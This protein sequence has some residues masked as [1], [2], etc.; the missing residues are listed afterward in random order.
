[1]KRTFRSIGDQEGSQEQATKSEDVSTTF[2]WHKLEKHRD[3]HEAEIEVAK[4]LIS[5]FGIYVSQAG[6]RG[7]S[8]DIEI[9]DGFPTRSSRRNSLN[10]IRAGKYEVKSLW[11]K[12]ENS[13]FD[14][15]FKIG[16]RGERL[17]GRRDAA[18][19]AFVLKLEQYLEEGTCETLVQL[20]STF[21]GPSM[22]Q[23]FEQIYSFIDDALARKHSLRFTESLKNLVGKVKS[24]P[25]LSSVSLDVISS[26]VSTSDIEGAFSDIEGIFVVAGPIYTLITRDEFAHLLSFDSSSS[27][28]PKLRMLGVIPSEEKKPV[29]NDKK[30][31]K[32]KKK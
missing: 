32:K 17:Y 14:R 3:P 16:V 21:T 28:G 29:S 20:T 15:R 30:K 10:P 11:R 25:E 23:R 4:A 31:G 26:D 18:I 5:E 12:S 7:Q 6:S 22:A 19:K 27:E 13:R 8:H 2:G 1:M 24:I 9:L